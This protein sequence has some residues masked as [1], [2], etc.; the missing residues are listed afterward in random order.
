MMVVAK[1]SISGKLAQGAKV[2]EVTLPE[3]YLDYA[4]VF[5]EEAFQKMPPRWAYDHPIELNETF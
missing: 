3:E 2:V 1:T 4:K 5:S